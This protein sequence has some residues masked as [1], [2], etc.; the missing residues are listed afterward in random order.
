MGEKYNSTGTIYYREKTGNLKIKDDKKFIKLIMLND[1]EAFKALEI[2]AKKILKNSYPD[3]PYEE[4]DDIVLVAITKALQGFNPDKKA[5]ILT[6]LTSKIRGE[7]SDWRYRKNADERKIIKEINTNRDNYMFQSTKD[8]N[9][10][11]IIQVT[12]ENPESKIIEEDIYTRQLK[13]F[14]MAYSQL[15]MFSQYIL[16]RLV[17]EQG[18]EYNDEEK[19]KIRTKKE[20]YVVQSLANELNMTKH[21][22]IGLRN[23]SLSLILTKV[24]RST[25]LTDKEK[26]KIKEIHGL[27]DINDDNSSENEENQISKIDKTLKLAKEE[28]E[29]KFSKEE[30]EEMKKIDEEINRYLSENALSFVF[31]KES[32]EEKN[33]ASLDFD[34]LNFDVDD[35]F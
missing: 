11:T 27:V 29:G 35:D 4:Y 25:Y 10:V 30:F 31:N 17:M 9:E 8:R 21:K 24:L 6:Y 18:E 26:E 16:N 13:A 2:Y 19:E 34:G 14:R 12:N 1:E 32:E 15:P 5:G 33:Q 7:V 3:V 28:I 20:N 23:F 22:I